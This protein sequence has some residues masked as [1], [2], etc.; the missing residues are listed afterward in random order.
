MTQ[1][2]LRIE[3]RKGKKIGSDQQSIHLLSFFYFYLEVRSIVVSRMCKRVN[4][5]SFVTVLR[6]MK[7]PTI[8]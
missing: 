7:T 3:D 2:D 4:P 1:G 6:S 5:C 8:I